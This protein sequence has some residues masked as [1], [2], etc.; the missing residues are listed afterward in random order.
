MTKIQVQETAQAHQLSDADSCG[1][2]PNL[3]V[4]VIPLSTF[5][6]WYN[7]LAVTTTFEDTFVYIIEIG[8]RGMCYFTR[9]GV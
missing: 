4:Y 1:L 9:A 7:K 5:P 2:L 3:Y 8:L 6:A